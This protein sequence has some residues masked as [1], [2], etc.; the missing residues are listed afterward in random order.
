MNIKLIFLVILISSL[1]LITGCGYRNDMVYNDDYL[2]SE[3][4]KEIISLSSITECSEKTPGNWCYTSNYDGSLIGEACADTYEGCLSARVAESKDPSDCT[5][6]QSQ[7]N[8]DLCWSNL[9]SNTK[10]T[11]Y[12]DKISDE[13]LKSQ[14]K[15]EEAA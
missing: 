3:G 10:D 14:C 5:K 2:P 9:A 11:T 7:E 1:F 6:I 4:E 12:C 13:Y 8:K 15:G